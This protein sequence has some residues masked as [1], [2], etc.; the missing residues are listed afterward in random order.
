MKKILCYLGIMKK[1]PVILKE[2]EMIKNLSCKDVELINKL[3]V[4]CNKKRSI[5]SVKSTNT[6]LLSSN[7]REIDFIELA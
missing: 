6:K 7:P 4:T 1:G 3:S 2:Y 5:K